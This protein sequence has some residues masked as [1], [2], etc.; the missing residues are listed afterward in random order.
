MKRAALVLA[1]LF[2]ASCGSELRQRM[3]GIRTTIASA[4]ENGAYKCAPKELAMAESHADFTDDELDYGNYVGA[5]EEL[6][7]ADTNAKL[8]FER[9]P[10]ERCA[11]KV[12][13]VEKKT[14]VIEVKLL[15][16]DHDGVPDKDDECPDDPGPVELKGCPDRDKDGVLDKNDKC[17]DTP[18]PVENEGC[19]WPDKDK[20]GV[21][22]KDDKC[23]EV[24]GPAENQGCPWPDTDG[25]GFL[26]KDD[27]C[28]TVP[29]VAPDGCPQYKMIVVKDDKIE[30][31]QKVHFA[32]DKF[33]ILKDSFAMLDEV[34]DVLNKRPTVEVRIEGHTDSRASHKHN[35][36][37]S[38]NRASS[39][40]QYLVGK[41]VSDARMNAIGYGPDQPIDDNR[42][43]IG[44]ENNR[45]VEFF[46]TKQ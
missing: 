37:L 27:K 6:E 38:Q 46:I 14:P 15:D 17:P 34:A 1:L 26:D 13:V 35:M 8:A 24:P 36:T 9:S 3:K 16:R 10:K 39:V 23:P 28:P 33:K 22:D 11:P 44:R 42:T 31:K 32:T 4:R 30:L 45:R 43:S 29:G 21:F 2:A 12:A 18:G 7:I 25:D 19:P 20:D 40:K 5:K 41:G